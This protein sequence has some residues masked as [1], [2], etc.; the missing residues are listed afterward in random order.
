MRRELL[1]PLEELAA[2]AIGGAACQFLRAPLPWMI[3]PLLAM[4]M[5]KFSGL[6]L[7]SPRGGRELGQLG[8][9]TALG[10]YFKPQVSREV[11]D[12]WYLLIAAAHVTRVLILVTTTAQLFRLAKR[13]SAQ[14]A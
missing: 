9:G 11:L 4:A 10:L 8:I 5:L 3:G 13:L 1:V 2:C 6:H 14:W 7:T 12:N